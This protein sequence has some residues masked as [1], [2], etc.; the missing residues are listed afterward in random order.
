MQDAR[1]SS[2][3]MPCACCS[4]VPRHRPQ[5]LS[6]AC[7]H[8]ESISVPPSLLHILSN[9]NCWKNL[10]F[11]FEPVRISQSILLGQEEGKAAVCALAHSITSQ[12]SGLWRK[13]QQSCQETWFNGMPFKN[14]VHCRGTLAPHNPKVTPLVPIWQ[15]LSTPQFWAA[16]KTVHTSSK[17]TVTE[18]QRTKSRDFVFPV[19]TAKPQNWYL[20][21]KPPVSFSLSFPSPSHTRLTSLPL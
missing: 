10:W 1:G 14:H 9:E 4:K 12:T 11:S 6:P 18:K 16:E 3:P 17:T 8:R 13:P 19:N 2:V 20:V 15:Q 5:P 7:L 21:R